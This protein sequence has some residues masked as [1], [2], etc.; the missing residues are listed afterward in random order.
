[1]VLPQPSPVP[2]TPDG[3]AL[4]ELVAAAPSAPG[5]TGSA[6]TLVGTETGEPGP[7]EVVGEPIAPPDR[8]PRVQLGRVT[9]DP[10]L[11]S[12]AIERAARAQLYWRLRTCRQVDGTPPPPDSIVLAFTLRRDGTVDPAT[13][14]ADATEP[15]LQT[16]A[17]CVLR[18][19]SATPFI[20]PEAGRDM[21]T[22]VLI[23]WPSVD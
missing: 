17:A 20:G 9:V 1:M 12:P 11:S 10:P 3:G 7:A 13:V 23:T 15:G 4:G 16:V 18:T 14:R 6:G 5:P 8:G 2:R 19:F 22:R 21:P